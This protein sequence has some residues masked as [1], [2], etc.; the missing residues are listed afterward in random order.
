MD[1]KE[2]GFLRFGKG[3]YYSTNQKWLIA[4]NCFGE[5]NIYRTI[6]ELTGEFYLTCRTLK[7]AKQE[8]IKLDKLYV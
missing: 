6:R 2:I 1:K 5:W 7:E 4:K 3:A 8:V